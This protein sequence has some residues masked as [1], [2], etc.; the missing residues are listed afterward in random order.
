VAGWSSFKLTTTITPQLAGY[1]HARVRVGKASSTFYLDP[2][3]VL[4]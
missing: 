4:T 3:V 1:I 2:K